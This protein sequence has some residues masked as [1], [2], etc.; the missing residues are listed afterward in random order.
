[1]YI[2]IF[3][4]G[5]SPALVGLILPLYEGTENTRALVLKLEYSISLTIA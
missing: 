1:M 3:S 5:S 2:I 4:V